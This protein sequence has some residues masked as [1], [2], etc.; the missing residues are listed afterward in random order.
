MAHKID[1]MAYY[2]EVPWHG[3]GVH[4]PERLHAGP[5]MHAAGLDWEVES[6]G[7]RGATRDDKGR[8]SR[9]EIVRMPRPGKSE[10]EV[11]LGLAS[12]HYVPLQNREAFDFFDPVV[13]Q[14]RAVF[15]TAGS[16]GQG[17]CIWVLAKLPD[18]IQ[19]VR[20]DDCM[21]YLLLS[22]RHDGHGSVVVKFTSIRVVCNNTLMLALKD[23][24]NAYR[25]RHSKIM[26]VRLSEIGEILGMATRMY[27]E[28]GDLFRAMAARTLAKNRL[29]DFLQAVYPV[30]APQKKNGKRPEKWEQIDRLI[31]SRADL[32][33]PGVRG[34]L[35][36]AYN[37]VTAFEDYRQSSKPEEPSARLN[38]VWFGSS[39]DRKLT[40]FQA[41][42]SLVA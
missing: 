25:V 4:V 6:R 30:T 24:Q 42:R 38:R 8:Y 34:T 2:G 20:D 7:A 12:R 23:G 14:G 10:G 35:W 40:A 36:A 22:N 33:L 5:M 39:A 41:A 21:Q 27:A 3:L 17:E 37:A 28:A 32:Q 29:D 26:T 13:D 18:V 31:D 16:L 1:S 9:Y 11:L 15:E 19:V